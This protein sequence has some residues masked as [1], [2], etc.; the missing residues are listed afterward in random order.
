MN[1]GP[2]RLA[3]A[4][5]FLGHINREPRTS[6]LMATAIALHRHHRKYYWAICIVSRS[7][8]SIGGNCIAYRIAGVDRALSAVRLCVEWYV[9]E[10]VLFN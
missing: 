10:L 9:F 4:M 3:P 1:F 5:T 8:P 2:G 7:Q 6:I